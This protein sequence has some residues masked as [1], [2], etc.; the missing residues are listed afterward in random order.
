VTVLLVTA[1]V[2]PAVLVL[3][4]LGLGRVL[5]R[6]DA[7]RGLPPALVRRTPRG[8]LS[9]VWRSVPV[10]LRAPYDEASLAS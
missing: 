1:V 3:L 8:P 10:A 9:M 2:W 7:R 4:G 5:R 6:A